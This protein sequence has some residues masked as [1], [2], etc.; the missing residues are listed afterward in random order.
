MNEVYKPVCLQKH[1]LALAS[2]LLIYELP[3]FKRQSTRFLYIEI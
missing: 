1:L 2:L 3:S